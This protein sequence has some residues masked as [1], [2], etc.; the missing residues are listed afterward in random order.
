MTETMMK[1]IQNRSEQNYTN[2][3][4]DIRIGTLY[5]Q[6][7]LYSLTMEKKS[8]FI[9]HLWPFTQDRLYEI[10]NNVVIT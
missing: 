4:L 6:W 9:S 10:A 3:G 2:T 1:K 7:T 5:H 8:A